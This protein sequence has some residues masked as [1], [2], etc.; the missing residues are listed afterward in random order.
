MAFDGCIDPESC[1]GLTQAS[2]GLEEAGEFRAGWTARSRTVE[3]V[4]RS[5]SNRSAEDLHAFNSTG[6][7]KLICTLRGA[8][9]K[10]TYVFIEILPRFRL[11]RFVEVVLVFK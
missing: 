2:S 11:A 3:R 9:R 4:F 8:R 7:L 10:A 1:A 5:S 6:R